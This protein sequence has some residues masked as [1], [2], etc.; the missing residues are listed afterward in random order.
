MSNI[1]TYKNV[2]VYYDETNGA[3]YIWGKEDRKEVL[4]ATFYI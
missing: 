3:I 1:T 4:K 2:D